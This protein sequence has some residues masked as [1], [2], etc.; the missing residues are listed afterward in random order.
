MPDRRRTLLC[1]GLCLIMVGCDSDPHPTT[2]R[3]RVTRE[4]STDLGHE[5]GWGAGSGRWTWV[6]AETGASVRVRHEL[7]PVAGGWRV[8]WE[9]QGEWPR[10]PG[11][12]I[13]DDP[14]SWHAWQG[15]LADRQPNSA[16]PGFPLPLPVVPVD[17]PAYPH[18]LAL[19]Q[20]LTRDWF[21]GVVAPWPRPVVPVR[22]FPAVNDS[23]DLAA[24]LRQAMTIWNEGPGGPYFREDP[25]ADW[26]LRLVHFPL[27]SLRPPAACRITRLDSVGRPLRAHIELGNDYD[28]PRDRVYALRALVHE[29]GHGLLLWGHSR[30]R[31]HCLWGG[32]PP[33][34]AAPSLDERK[35]A[36]WWRGLPEGLDLMA[37]GAVNESAGC[38]A[39]WPPADRP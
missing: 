31:D 33:L 7:E 15:S 35:A 38:T 36:L 19:L 12:L 2:P 18:L 37:Y 24:T 10:G 25:H 26:G 30:D 29:L 14:G 32:A 17:S 1:C 34:V 39:A 9:L 5:T 22:I 23:V 21:A 28:R 3:W 8:V 4:W 16:A 6:D 27:R 13:P 11:R 20:D